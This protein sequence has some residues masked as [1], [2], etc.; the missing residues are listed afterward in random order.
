M[1]VV[2]CVFVLLLQSFRMQVTECRLQVACNCV[3]SIETERSI[4]A[5]NRRDNI[6]QHVVDSKQIART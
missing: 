6:I 2:L 4:G 1:R 5:P 3:I